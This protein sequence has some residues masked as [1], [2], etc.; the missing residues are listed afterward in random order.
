MDHLAASECWCNP[1]VIPVERPDGSI[2]FVSA[3]NEP[4]MN[5][6]DEAAR[7]AKIY[8]AMEIVRLQTDG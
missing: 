5:P 7:A 6:E 8:E 3:H 2:G 4:D 1:T